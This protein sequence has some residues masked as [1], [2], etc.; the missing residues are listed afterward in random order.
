MKNSKEIENYMLWLTKKNNDEIAAN[1]RF[2]IAIVEKEEEAQ[3]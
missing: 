3:I 2:E 1:V